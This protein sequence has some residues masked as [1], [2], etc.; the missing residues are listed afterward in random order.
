MQ[1]LLVTE[2]IPRE[3]GRTS[4]RF[5]NGMEVLL[6]KGE[7][8][9]LGLQEQTVISREKYD[10][11]I[12]EILGTRA[13]KRAMFLLERMDR[14][15]HQLRDKLMQNGYP[16]V[17]VDLA[18]DYV[19]KYH[20]IDDLR[21]ATNYISYQQKRKS[22]QKLKIDLLTKG[23]DKNV[24]E[25]ALDEAFDSDE[26]IKIRQL[27]EKKHYDPKECDRK[28]KQKTYQYLMRRGF[29]GSDILHVMKIW[30]GYEE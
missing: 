8:R 14:T 30:D 25:Q 12:Y 21:Y 6:Y 28:E 29:K 18:I 16:A 13:K 17:C 1:E 15:E 10:E 11:I 19:K 20:Y 26:Q 24:I 7:V 3:K 9:K 5:D 23:I 27:L 4:I 22:R 2:V